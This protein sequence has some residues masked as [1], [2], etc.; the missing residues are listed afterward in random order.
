MSDGVFK[1]GLNMEEYLAGRA[2]EIQDL[3]DRKLFKDVVE[4]LFLE[5]YR[6]TQAEYQAL[7]DRIF[8][9]MQSVR[10]D[11]AISI[12][13]TDRVHY[14]A[15]DTFL[16]PIRKEDVEPH[17]FATDELL[18]CLKD[19]AAYPLYSVFLE[20]DYQTV[21][22]FAK[23]GRIYHGVVQTDHGEFRAQC[24]VR[25]ERTYLE[26][27]EMLYHIFS[28]NFL[29]WTTV[30]TAYLHKFFRVELLS[31]EDLDPKETIQEIRV[32]FEEYQNM[33]RYDRIPLWNLVQISEKS[34]TYP[35]PCVDKINFDHRIFA[36]RL[37][38]ECQYL[39][40]N[41][42]VEL[43]NIR[44]LHGDLILTC[45]EEHPHQ[46][47]LYRV[48]HPCSQTRTGYPV[49]SN[50]SRES[51]S[52]NLSE[53]YRR[54][55]KTRAEIAR[56]LSAY[57]YED[58]VCFQNVTLAPTG[59]M[60][61]QTYCMDDFLLDELRTEHGGTDMILFF[62]SPKPEHFLTLDIMSFLVTQVQSLFPEYNCL[63]QLL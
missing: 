51:F 27:V 42:D 28:T 10:S 14:D 49:L 62:T 4:K 5:L 47:L 26:Q 25:P 9:E 43:T 24:T 2:L 12:G 46:W 16:Q 30:C 54:G 31:I 1:P 60:Q 44:R 3:K 50:L 32:E 39:V 29:P 63:G 15:T 57:H 21:Q 8:G 35:E 11:Y 7:E 45:P 61:R 6:Y 34:S 18:S 55:V 56:V 38:P 37:D 17:E 48:N 36:H 59:R 58:Y 52:G 19:G 40:A 33:V 53:R 20:A 23:E 13:L 22:N 41:P